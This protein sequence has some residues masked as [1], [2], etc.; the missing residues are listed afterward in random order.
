MWISAV[1]AALVN[2]FG[3]DLLAQVTP[4][5]QLNFDKIYDFFEGMVLQPQLNEWIWVEPVI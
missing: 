3:V 4:C 2:L 5:P 1:P